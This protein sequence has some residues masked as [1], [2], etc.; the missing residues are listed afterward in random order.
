MVPYNDYD[1]CFDFE[2]L[3]QAGIK[4]ARGVRWKA[5]VQRYELFLLTN[6][7]EI[8]VQIE[9]GTWQ[10]TTGR[11]YRFT[12]YERGHRRDIRSTTIAE[13]NGQKCLCD[14]SLV[15]AIQ[16]SL[17]YDNGATMKDKG[18]TFTEKRL[19]EMLRRFIQTIGAEAAY[20]HGY[21]VVYDFHG[22]FD[23]IDHMILLAIVTRFYTDERLMATIRKLVDDFGDMGLGLGS[24]ISQILAL[25]MATDLDHMIKDKLSVKAYPRY[26]DDGV[27]LLP[28]KE[29]AVRVMN[30]IKDMAKAL[31]LNINEKKTRIV[32][33]SRGFTF[34]KIHYFIKPTGHI[35]RHA[36]Q[37]G[38][39]RMRNRLRAYQKK[40]GAGTIKME[41]VDMSMEAYFANCDRY[42]SGRTKY[43]FW[44]RYHRMFPESTA[45]YHRKRKRFTVEEAIQWGERWRAQHPNGSRQ[46]FKK[47]W[48]AAVKERSEHIEALQVGYRR[49]DR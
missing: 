48:N 11:F 3:W 32:K 24:Q 40:L 1:T 47:A 8:Y 5:S 10:R 17:I 36:C 15:P 21:A 23:S 30:A 12:L 27:C 20:L 19:S 41:N 18:I 33:L 37:G 16:P 44:Q 45:F 14:Y 43:S 29:E 13:R 49:I 35:V 22:Y 26:M 46:D 31:R 38:T 2:H 34:L 6:V 28:T 9:I 39:K 42:D 4:C 7:A 25:L